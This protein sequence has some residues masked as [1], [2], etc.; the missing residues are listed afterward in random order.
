MAK[1]TIGGIISS[2]DLPDEPVFCPG[3]GEELGRRQH[4][5]VEDVKS[6]LK[7]WSGESIASEVIRVQDD[8]KQP[9]E[10]GPGPRYL[11]LCAECAEQ[12]LEPESAQDA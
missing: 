6:A 5:F 10:I 12:W 11:Y 2:D 9:V 7:S 1:T 3:C 8:R 4:L